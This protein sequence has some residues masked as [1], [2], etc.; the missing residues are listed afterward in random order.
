[1]TTRRLLLLVVVLLSSAAAQQRD[2]VV[3][4]EYAQRPLTRWWWFASVI[5]TNDVAAQLDWVERSGFGGVEIAWVY[6]LKGDS[7]ARRD[8]WLSPAW[9]RSAAFAKRHAT[10]LGLQCDFTFG[11][12][13]PFGDSRVPPEDATVFYGDSTARAAMRL[14][15]EHPVRGRVLNHL[16]HRAFERYAAR[17]GDALAPA[18]AGPPS[19]LFCDSWEVETRK[20]WTRGFDSAFSARFGYDV[21]PFMDSLLAPGNA[22][23]FFD[24]MTL[25]SDYTIGEFYR[26]FTA[27]AHARGAF[28]RAQCGGAPADLLDAFAAVDVPES[29]AV[30]FDAPF[31]RIAASAAA[32]HG[33]P[34][35]TAESFTCAYGWKGW[36]GPG[37]HQGEE[38]LADLKRIADAL[39]ANG[40]NGIIWHGMPYNPPGRDENS[41]PRC[42]SRRRRLSPPN[43]RAS[44]RTSKKFRRPCGAGGRTPTRPCISRR[45]MPGWRAN[46]PTRSNCPGH[47]GSTKCGARGC[48]MNC[49]E[50]I[51][52][53]STPPPSPPRAWRTAASSMETRCSTC[54]SSMRSTSRRRHCAR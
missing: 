20:L 28:S 52:S 8:P 38:K 37:P 22:G 51:R 17:V 48:R 44:M 3:P 50:E 9:S 19:A 36:P 39:F 45:R 15:W 18:I 31:S 46:I 16:D 33:K 40:V 34:V 27:Q 30:L 5:D 13:W 12:L 54:W 26:P 29:E 6:P 1:M 7:A 35:V 11:T 41:T 4:R 14:T 47:G 2:G 21:R 24:Y 25:L 10:R 32:L 42:M 23:V 53:G 43:F 49:E